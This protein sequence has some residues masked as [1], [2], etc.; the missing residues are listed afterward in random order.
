MHFF[1]GLRASRVDYVVLVNSQ[2]QPTGSA[3]GVIFEDKP[4]RFREDLNTMVVPIGNHQVTLRIERQGVGRSKL[5]R[6]ASG[7][8]DDTEKPS[9]LIEHRDS[10][11][12]IRICHISLALGNIGVTIGRVGHHG[13]RIGERGGRISSHTRP[14]SSGPYLRD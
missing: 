5:A 8:A 7:F 3:E 11:D 12:E 14:K 13:R 9:G 6:P 2:P 1:S 10:T 4:T